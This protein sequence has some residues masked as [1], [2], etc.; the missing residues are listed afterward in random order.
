M[1][2]DSGSALDGL[3]VVDLTSTTTG[4]HITQTLA[5]FGADVT[6]VEPPGGT[7]LRQLPA[8]VPS[9]AT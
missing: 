1:T 5:D 8:S 3:V 7:P 4:A 6:L 2:A 9:V